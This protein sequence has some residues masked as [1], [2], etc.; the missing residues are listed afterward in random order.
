MTPTRS[1]VGLHARLLRR[2]TLVLTLLFFAASLAVV[3]GY[4]GLYPAGTDRS[5][6]VALGENPGFRALLG[7]GAGLD[8]AG[9][10]T[11]WRFGGPAVIIVAVWSYL[12]TSR[13]LRGEEDAGRA[14]LV[15]SGAVTGSTVVRSV[16]VVVAAASV[17]LAGGSGLGMVAGGA[18][19]DGSALT[20]ASVA[21][22]GFV[23][24]ALGIVASQVLP[25]R[26]AAALTCGGFVAGAFL[27][28]AVANTRE[29]LEW[30]RW[31]TPFGWSEL[32]RPFG[33]RA[34]VPFVVAAAATA[35]LGLVGAALARRRDLGGAIV[36][37]RPSRSPRP[38]GLRSSLGFAGRQGLPRAVVWVVPLLV[39]TTTFGLLSRDVGEFFNSNETFVEIFERF[40]VDPSVPV[41]AFLGFVVSTFAIVG[42]CFA[43]S[44][45][46]AAREEEASTRLDNLLTRAVTRRQWFAGRLLVTVAGV[47]ALAIGLASGAGAGA[48]WGGADVRIAEFTTV[49]VNA[50]PVAVFFLG[51]A[52]VVFATAPR[53]TTGFG[54]GLVGTAFVWQIVGSAIRAP[55]W[56]LDLTPFAHVAPVPSRGANVGAGLV[57]ATLGVAGCVLAVEIFA[58]RDL[59][60]A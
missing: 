30:L 8:T 57:L 32:V 29:G 55:Q 41:R 56:T 17:V 51:I 35:L 9:G 52:A 34:A 11:A 19:L 27:I 48:T 7:S 22:G 4:E 21:I 40:D 46:G 38:A 44:E 25:T 23:F 37:D 47:A 16:M 28:R 18:P 10:F 15:W 59:Q 6:A 14:E 24:G 13:L 54:F 12:V 43:V 58:R 50:V 39:L 3:A 26:R 2:S 36:S 45:V 53:A 33:D 60:S 49:A 31:G 5:Q 20:T 1:L 42:V